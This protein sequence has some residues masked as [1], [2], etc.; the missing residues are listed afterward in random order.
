MHTGT[1]CRN[2]SME[3]PCNKQDVIKTLIL[4]V[5]SSRNPVLDFLLGEKHRC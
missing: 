4:I 1:L 5:D 2:I 3:L